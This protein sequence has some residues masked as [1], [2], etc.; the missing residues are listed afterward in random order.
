MNHNAR[1]HTLHYCDVCGRQIIDGQSPIPPFVE[2]STM[3]P[4]IGQITSESCLCEECISKTREND[5]DRGEER[6]LGTEG[7]SNGEEAG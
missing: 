3:V 2:E 7:R 5:H 6:F 4:S 1:S